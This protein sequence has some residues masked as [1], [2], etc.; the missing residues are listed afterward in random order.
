M[1]ALL[2]GLILAATAL[3]AIPVSVFSAQI[4]ASLPRR[5]PARPLPAGRPSVAV[6]VP[7]HDEATTIAVTLAAIRSQL[8]AGDRLL[9]VADN[10]TDDTAAIAAAAGAE[11]VCRSDAG[12]RGKG[13]ALDAGLR[14]MARTGPR[15]TVLFVDADCIVGPA[16]VATLS[17]LCHAEQRPIQAAYVLSVLPGAPSTHRI[18][19]FSHMVKT[20][21]R[22]LGWRRLRCPCHLNGTGMALPW[23]LAMAADLAS[24]NLTE[25][26]KLGMDLAMAGAAPRYCPDVRVDS[27]FPE[28]RD[29]RRAQQ[30]RWEHGHLALIGRYGPRLAWQ[31]IRRRDP[32]LGLMA[33][34]LFVPPLAALAMGCAGL[35]GIAALLAL[36]TGRLAPLVAAAALLA[37]LSLSLLLAALRWGRGLVDWRDLA[38][39]PRFL[40]GKAGILLGYARGPQ[41]EWV[42]AER[43]PGSLGEP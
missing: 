6:I 26:L 28:S 7:A 2:E 31:A 42:R 35:V 36:A 10:C 8:R 4:L 11:V 21:G 40:A 13:Y 5:G 9:V 17:A 14:R 15:D 29:G 25:D 32:R 33:L 41:K 16:A 38:A 34:D 20:V 19:A 23:G 24:G 39:V 43:R 3:A 22:P 37:A 27:T 18:A 30:M 1:I 12:R